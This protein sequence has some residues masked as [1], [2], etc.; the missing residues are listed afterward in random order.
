MPIV[1]NA[2]PAPVVKAGAVSAK[3]SS[4]PKPQPPQPTPRLAGPQSYETYIALMAAAGIAA[5]LGLR[6]L[7]GVSRSVYLLPLFLTLIVG[8]VPLVITLFRNL[9]TREFGSDL[10]AG[11]STRRLVSFRVNLRG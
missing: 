7:T 11:I 8:G 5:H 2:G 1:H 10:L 6:Y 9:I 4:L 3:P